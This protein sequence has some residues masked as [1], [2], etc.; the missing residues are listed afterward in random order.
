MNIAA[1]C[2]IAIVC[3][4]LSLVIKKHN[5]EV[6]FALQICGC[7]IILLWVLGEASGAVGQIKELTEE[8]SVNLQYVEIV[9]KALGI[10]FIAEFANDCCKDSGCTALGNNVLLCGKVMILI[11]A[12]PM[13]KDL[14]SLA[15]G[16]LT[17]G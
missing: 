2:G 10:C 14:L 13:F 16:L 15:L 7:V 17:T 1:V 8:F 5:S 4:V 6:A 12:L 3:A 9:L 11:T